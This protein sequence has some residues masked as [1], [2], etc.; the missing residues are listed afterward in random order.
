MIKVRKKLIEVAIPLDAINKA[1]GREKSIRHGHP[2]TLHLWWARRP[3]AA[4]R[5]VIF[6]QLVD[7]PSASPERFPT[8]AAQ[9]VERQR[10]FRMIEQLVLW[11]STTDETLLQGIREEIHRCW[12]ATCADNPGNELF[13]ADSP[14]PFNDPFAGGGALPLEALRLGLEVFA[15]DL[16]PVSVL[17]NR[18]MIELPPK[19][20]GMSPVNPGRSADEALAARSWDGCKGL[21]ADVRY[22]GTRLRNEAERRIG[23]LFAPVEVT[24]EMAANRPDLSPIVGKKVNVIAWVWARTVKSPNPAFPGVEVPLAATFLLGTK[25][26]KEVHIEPV[27]GQSNYRFEVRLGKAKDIDIAKTGT[28]LSRGANFRCLMSGAPISGD[29]I[30][31]EGKA[32]RMGA[33]LMAVVAEGE[34]GRIYLPPTDETES[35]ARSIQPEWLPEGSL[36]PDARAFTPTLYGLE[37]WA[38]LYT[39]RQLVVLTTLSDL[40]G[41]VRDEVQRD[42]AATKIPDP[43]GYAN[44]IATYLGLAVGRVSDYCSTICTWAHNPQMEI[45]R[46]TFA[47]Q[48]LPMTWDF[49]EANPF[50]TSTGSI[51]IVVGWIA[52]AIERLPTKGTAHA[53]QQNAMER[54]DV[55]KAAV[56][57]TDPPYYDNVPYADLSD[58]FYAWLRPS[59]K[60]VHPDLFATLAVPKDEE[61]VACAY[62]HGGKLG[63]RAFFLEGMTRVMH[64]LA[65]QAHPA[66]PVT[67]YY[68]FKQT[69]SD[70]VGLVQE[71]STGW[72]TFLGALIE[73][74]FSVCGTWPFGPSGRGGPGTSKVMR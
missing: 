6:S 22:Y 64:R 43:I 37:K 54:P 5:A 34:R 19:Y 32:G 3:L 4:A 56:V 38:D 33:R 16:N 59:L 69:E 45:V 68:A 27:V 39:T 50:G 63:A 48:A 71:T 30:K 61:L 20:S 67:I 47:R 55:P 62:R 28:K 51:E 74:G 52:K 26:G 23:S 12:R 31:A 41:K 29:Y 66:F 72:E 58:Y 7:D 36:V 25:P 1:S 11:E 42:A 8:E 49:A 9:E 24:R 53:R 35:L 46:G 70:D 14:P 40:I 10:L 13:V 18:A 2:S 60:T 17:I 15:D 44:A 73:A 65:K 21:A 57:S